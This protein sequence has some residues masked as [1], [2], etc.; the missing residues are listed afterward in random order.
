MRAKSGRNIVMM[1]IT[2]EGSILFRTNH[3]PD[4]RSS[5]A[6]VVCE[7]FAVLRLAKE[8]EHEG[9]AL[10]YWYR[11]TRID[12]LDSLTA[13]QLVHCGRARDVM[14]FLTAIRVGLRH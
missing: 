5:P 1:P 12:E 9:K 11:S 14:R 4:Q 2:W 3:G 10:M 7:V 8:I 13:E 6:K